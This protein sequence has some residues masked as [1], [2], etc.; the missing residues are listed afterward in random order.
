MHDTLFFRKFSYEDDIDPQIEA[1]SHGNNEMI[2][3]HSGDASP[4][5]PMATSIT[6]PSMDIVAS[7][8]INANANVSGQR[9]LS[10]VISKSVASE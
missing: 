4:V 9:S 8:S 3:V 10:S 7:T 2:A 6:I 5:S 1:S